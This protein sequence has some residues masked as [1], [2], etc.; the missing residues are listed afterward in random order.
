MTKPLPTYQGKFCDTLP[1]GIK[2]PLLHSLKFNVFCVPSEEKVFV[3]CFNRKLFDSYSASRHTEGFL[4]WILEEGVPND[5][6]LE[7][8]GASHYLHAAVRT[9]LPGSNDLTEMD[10]KSRLASTSRPPPSTDT[11]PV[12]FRLLW[13]HKGCCSTTT[14][15]FAETSSQNTSCWAHCFTCHASKCV[16]SDTDTV[17]GYAL[18]P[19]NSS[20]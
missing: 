11:R 4:V 3:L 5:M 8:D 6:L 12:W 9:V 1:F 10:W 20:A 19:V 17:L 16:D 14:H 15:Y 18:C 2:Q 7:Q 13:L